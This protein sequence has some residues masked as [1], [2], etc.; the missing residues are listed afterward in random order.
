MSSSSSRSNK[1]E[2]G[3]KA[4]AAKKDPSST[5]KKSASSSSVTPASPVRLCKLARRPDFDGYG[6]GVLVDEKCK[7]ATVTTVEKGRTC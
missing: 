7:L 3:G 5:G 2:D 6:F 4:D 1:K